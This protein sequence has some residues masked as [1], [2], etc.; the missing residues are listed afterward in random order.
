MVL[1]IGEKYETLSIHIKNRT[2]KDSN[3]QNA[4]FYFQEHKEVGLVEKVFWC[5]PLETPTFAW[6]GHEVY[7]LMIILVKI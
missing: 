2:L 6:R 1:A 3:H 7:F 4:V 5:V